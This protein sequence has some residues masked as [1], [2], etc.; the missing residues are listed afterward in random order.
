MKSPNYYDLVYY[1][2]V[3]TGDIFSLFVDYVSAQILSVHTTLDKENTL[4]AI[5]L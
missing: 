1:H 3:F 2:I 4:L 5:Q